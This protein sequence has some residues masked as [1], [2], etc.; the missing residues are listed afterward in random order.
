MSVSVLF[1]L[2][3]TNKTVTEL[4]LCNCNNEPSNTPNQQLLKMHTKNI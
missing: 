1:D 4:F 2:P 3:C